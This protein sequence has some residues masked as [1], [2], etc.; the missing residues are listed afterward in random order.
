MVSRER[1]ESISIRFLRKT[2][3]LFY[4]PKCASFLEV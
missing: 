4:E 3:G 2:F 1:C